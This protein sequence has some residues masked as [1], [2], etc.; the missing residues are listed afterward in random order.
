MRAVFE[1]QTWAACHIF[2]LTAREDLVNGLFSLHDGRLLDR[3]FH[4][5]PDFNSRDYPTVSVSS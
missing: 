1:H 5:L 2:G 3:H 4:L